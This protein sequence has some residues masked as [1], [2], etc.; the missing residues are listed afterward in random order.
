MFRNMRISKH[1]IL[2]IFHYVRSSPLTLLTFTYGSTQLA[3]ILVRTVGLK[4][5]HFFSQKFFFLLFF[6]PDDLSTTLPSCDVQITSAILPLSPKLNTRLGL[7]P[8]TVSELPLRLDP[9]SRIT[10][11]HIVCAFH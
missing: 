2:P 9:S 8:D 11:Y 4:A 3:D 6:P 10:P 7:Q 5:T 1:I